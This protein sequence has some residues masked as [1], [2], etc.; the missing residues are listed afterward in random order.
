MSCLLML[1]A[2]HLQCMLNFPSPQS[3][4]SRLALLGEQIQVRFDN[5]AR[6]SPPKFQLFPSN[7]K[8][9]QS[10]HVWSWIY[11]FFFFLW[12]EGHTGINKHSSIFFSSSEP[13]KRQRSHTNRDFK[14]SSEKLDWIICLYSFSQIVLHFT[15]A[16][17]KCTPPSHWDISQ[18]Q[19]SLTGAVPVWGSLPSGWSTSEYTHC[20]QAELEKR[21]RLH[22]SNTVSFLKFTTQ[23]SSSR[24]KGMGAKERGHQC[25]STVD[26]ETEK[27]CSLNRC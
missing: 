20:R 12:E 24:Q 21:Q 14:T 7:S 22:Q 5:S 17:N 10:S 15:P 6:C 26:L 8:E 23:S 1:L 9:S 18:T 25:Y 27:Y 13:A 3:S 19:V 2:W 16:L 11:V 4:I